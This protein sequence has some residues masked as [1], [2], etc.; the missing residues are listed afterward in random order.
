[1]VE[2]SV[3]NPFDDLY[4]VE[5]ICNHR[6]RRGVYEYEIKWKNYGSNE[7]TWE[8]A[9]HLPKWMVEEYNKKK[10]I[11]NYFATDKKLAHILRV[12]KDKW[13]NLI[14]HVQFHKQNGLEYVPAEWV[15][16]NY[17]MQM[18]AFYENR[19]YWKEDR[20]LIKVHY[21]QK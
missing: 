11:G 10:C 1:M 7:N 18:I 2:D 8:P 17:P 4:E 5:Q 13:G 19:S 3:T 15:N 14:A 9:T 12:E 20:Q 16:L 21:Y 6:S